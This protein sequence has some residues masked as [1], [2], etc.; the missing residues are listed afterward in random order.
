MTDNKATGNKLMKTEY[1]DSGK[2]WNTRD[3]PSVWKPD[4]YLESFEPSEGVWHVKVDKTGKVIY[5]RHVS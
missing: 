4:E 1:P 3:I 5:R 2:T